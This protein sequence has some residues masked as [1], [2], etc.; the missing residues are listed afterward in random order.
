[1]T[2]HD[3]VSLEYTYDEMEILGA[4]NTVVG[5]LLFNWML[6]L[7]C[8]HDLRFIWLSDHTNQH[9]SDTCIITDC[10]LWWTLLYSS[11][12]KMLPFISS[13]I[14]FGMGINQHILNVFVLDMKLKVLS[15]I[16]IIL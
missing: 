7:Y 8:H 14:S 4:L 13:E 1:M 15:K 9:E 10:Q 16:S 12:G 2:D 6:L 5:L 11:K 3:S